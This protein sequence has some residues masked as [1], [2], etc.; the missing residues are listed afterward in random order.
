MK[1]QKTGGGI[2][3]VYSCSYF[4]SIFEDCTNYT[5]NHI[6]HIYNAYT[7]LQCNA[8]QM[9]RSF[10]ITQSYFIPISG[11]HDRDDFLPMLDILVY[12]SRP[13]PFVLMHSTCLQ[14]LCRFH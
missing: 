8:F 1:R 7:E 3:V 6:D 11:Q 4:L 10:I 12:T 14:L 2:F 5:M 13:C 9:C